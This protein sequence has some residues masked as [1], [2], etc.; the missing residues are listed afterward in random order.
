[1]ITGFAERDA[2]PVRTDAAPHFGTMLFLIA[3]DGAFEAIGF[4]GADIVALDAEIIAVL[5]ERER[6]RKRDA[7]EAARQF[8]QDVVA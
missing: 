1:M 2:A 3:A 6:R 4:A 5:A 7:Q 8:V